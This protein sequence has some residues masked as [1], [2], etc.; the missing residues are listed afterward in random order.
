MRKLDFRITIGGLLILGGVL[1][2]LDTMGIIGDAGGIFWGLVWGAVGVFFLTLLVNDRQRNWWAA[3]PAFT[4]IGMAVTSFLP[5]SL[6][7]ISGLVFMGGISLAFWWVYFTDTTRWWAIIPAGVLLTLG[8]VSVLDEISGMDS[9]GLFFIGL[10]ITFLLVALLPGANKQSWAWI[11]AVVLLMF[12]T[13][14]V[15]SLGISTY[16]GPAMLIL[17][18]GYLVLRFFRNQSPEQ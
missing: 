4:L 1:A 16:V 12:G 11:P 14:L 13:I 2:L 10:G 3:F 8:L 6:E 7:I 17:V 18:G 9:G 5:N 15:P